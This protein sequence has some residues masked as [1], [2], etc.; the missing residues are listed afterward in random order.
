VGRSNDI[1]ALVQAYARYRQQAPSLIFVWLL[2]NCA[3]FF[4]VARNICWFTGIDQLRNEETTKENNNGANQT[5]R[6]PG[7][8]LIE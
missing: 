8:Y 4:I 2:K 5:K 1:K 7:A 6:Y 3:D